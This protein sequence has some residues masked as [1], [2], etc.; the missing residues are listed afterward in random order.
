MS[1]L[2]GRSALETEWP[3]PTFSN[4]EPTIDRYSDFFGH[5][6][7]I[8]WSLLEFGFCLSSGVATTTPTYRMMRS[9]ADRWPYSR[10]VWARTATRTASRS[11]PPRQ[12]ILNNGFDHV[13]MRL[14]IIEA[15]DVVE[16][17]AA[18]LFEGF[19]DLFINLF[20]RLDTVG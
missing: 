10:P 4:T 14:I 12:F 18:G 17:F 6:R 5:N 16:P 19:L 8:V 11:N 20:K 15:G 7:L 3:P 1:P 2:P 9:L 13:D